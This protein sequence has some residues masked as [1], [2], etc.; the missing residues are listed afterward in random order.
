MRVLSANK[1]ITFTL[2]LYTRLGYITARLPL[3]GRQIDFL[4]Q[5]H[6]TW[7]LQVLRYP[8]FFLRGMEADRNVKVVGGD[9]AVL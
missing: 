1:N 4:L 2:L 5:G 9:V 7:G 3:S 8:N 6:P